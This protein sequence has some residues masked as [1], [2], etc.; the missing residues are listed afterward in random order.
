MPKK[1]RPSPLADNIFR[2]KLAE[3]Q[4]SNQAT[5]V[6]ELPVHNTFIQF[7]GPPAVE[8]AKQRL[9]TAPAWIGTTSF[10]STVAAAMQAATQT[11][12]TSEAPAPPSLPGT[13]DSEGSL[14]ASL[15]LASPMKV[16]V[17]LIPDNGDASVEGPRKPEEVILK[18]AVMPETPVVRH[19]PRGPLA[20]PGEMPSRGSASHNDGLCKRCCFFPKGRCTNGFDCEFCHLEHDKRKR[21]KKK[22][23]KSKAQEDSDDSDSSD[24]EQE[25]KAPDVAGKQAEECGAAA[26]ATPGAEEA[27]PVTAG[28]PPG[29]TAAALSP[30]PPF[31]PAA[32]EAAQAAAAAAALSTT[33]DS[34]MGSPYD[35]AACA[36]MTA[37]AS[38]L[39]PV[40]PLAPAPLADASA[41]VPASPVQQRFVDAMSYGYGVASP[42]SPGFGA[43]SMY[44]QGNP[45]LPT[46]SAMLPMPA[47]P[48]LPPSLQGANAVQAGATVQNA[49]VLPGVGLPAPR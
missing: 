31:L 43:A 13:A 19:A 1:A 16:P 45:V 46:A 11:P 29:M 23:S 6:S 25:N 48:T 33:Y 2:E 5:D 27:A 41:R 7:G 3:L 12:P 47:A 34:Y 14:S 9:S 10:Q 36:S 21:K 4:S 28:L 37:A 32:A 8:G 49:S 18:D 44:C 22:K 42:G 39:A 20:A 26:A 17:A 30:T 38:P 24:N 15:W 40:P 35:Y